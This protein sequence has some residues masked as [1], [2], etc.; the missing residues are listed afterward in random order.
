MAQPIFDG[1]AHMALH[2]VAVGLQAG[3]EKNTRSTS[4]QLPIPVS[5]S[6][7]ILGTEWPSGP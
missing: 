4:D 5:E 3:F 6:G 7:V 2:I 1:L